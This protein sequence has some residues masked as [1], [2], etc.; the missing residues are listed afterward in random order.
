MNRIC[1]KYINQVKA[2]LPL[3]GKKEKVFVKKLCTD[4]CDYC[5]DNKIS[6]IEELYK[7]YGNPQEVAFEY[8]ALMEP[9]YV[10]K[11]INTAKLLKALVIGLL[12]LGVISVAF[13]S[14]YV[15]TEHQ[16]AEELSGITVE[17]IIREYD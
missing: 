12:T 13:F 17:Q 11:R 15:Y 9:E 5:E 16:I 7:G 3:W 10:S 4:L 8:I 6:T 2:M 1:K 14:F